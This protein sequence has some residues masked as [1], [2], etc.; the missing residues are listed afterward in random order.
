MTNPTN[1]Q[2]IIQRETE[3]RLF[4]QLSALGFSP[5]YLG[6]FANGR[7]EGYLDAAASGS[8]D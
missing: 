7:V 3:N 5:L 6:R 1:T 8:M 2:V 4:A